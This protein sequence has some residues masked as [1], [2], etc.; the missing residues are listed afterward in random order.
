MD[1]LNYSNVLAFLLF[2]KIEKIKKSLIFNEKLE[3]TGRN[4]SLMPCVF[5][6]KTIIWMAKEFTKTCLRIS[7]KSLVN[8][9]LH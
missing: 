5:V 9:A 6:S 3:K 4:P 7:I 1:P 2:L 8:T